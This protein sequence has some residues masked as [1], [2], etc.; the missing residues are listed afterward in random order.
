M[1]KTVLFFLICMLVMSVFCAA[2][3]EMS[4][5]DIITMGRIEQDND[6]NN[7]TE[8]IEWIV[9]EVKDGHA[10]LLS[11]YSLAAK[12][13]HYSKIDMTWAD[14][15]M[16][17]WLN[18][19]FFTT[20]FDDEEQ[21]RI[22]EVKIPA[23]ENP[24]YRTNAGTATDDRIFLLSLADAEEYFKT[25]EERLCEATPYAQKH[26][27]F[28][29]GNGKSEWW[30]RSP[31]KTNEY[32]A[33]VSSLGSVYPAGNSLNNVSCTVRPA[34]WVSLTDRSG[35]FIPY[36]IP[37]TP[38][39]IVLS[40]TIDLSELSGTAARD[41][42]PQILS[43]AEAEEMGLTIPVPADGESLYLGE[44]KS[45]QAE[46]MLAV[47]T[48][49]P[50]AQEM[51]NLN[52]LIYKANF[53]SGGVKADDLTVSVKTDTAYPIAEGEVEAPSFAFHDFCFTD[54]GAEAGFSF[55]INLPQPAG[56]SFT[57]DEA[58]MTFV[59]QNG[60]AAGGAAVPEDDTEAEAETETTVEAGEPA[61]TGLS[62]GD[63]FML[64][65]YEQDEKQSNGPE[66]VEWRVLS[67]EDGI[68][69]VISE[70]GLD[71]RAFHNLNV[72]ITWHASSLRNWLNGEFLAEL[73][74][75]PE[76]KLIMKEDDSLFLLSTEEA[77]TLFASDQDRR[78]LPTAYAIS[79]G[80]YVH[81]DT[82]G[83]IWWWLRT[84]S[85]NND[86]SAAC[87][88]HEGNVSLSGN[89]V[90]FKEVIRPAFYLDLAAY[91]K[92][93]EGGL[94]EGESAA[95]PSEP[96]EAQAPEETVDIPE[97]LEAGDE[98][99][100]G[101]FEQ[102]GDPDNGPEPIEWLTLA[103]DGSKALAVSRYILD[104]KAYHPS[105]GT[106]DW[107][108]SSL[109]K[110]LNDDFLTSSFNEAEQARIRMT[111]LS[112]PGNELFGTKKS[113]DTKDRVFLLSIEDAEN[114]FETDEER[115]DW[116]TD[117]AVTD[118]IFV[119][120]TAGNS[121]WWLRTAGASGSNAAY[122]GVAGWVMDRG[123][124]VENPYVGVRPALWLYLTEEAAEEEDDLSASANRV[125]NQPGDVGVLLRKGPSY[126][127][128][129]LRSILNG[130]S[131][132]LT[133]ESRRAEG[134]DWVR[135]RTEEGH[136]GWIP[137]SSL[138]Q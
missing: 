120:Q 44:A 27:A 89:G 84:Q 67:V 30:L 83:T 52:L 114:Y 48:M 92:F 133:G 73:F 130:K 93:L 21:A 64:G 121:W 38:E 59:R 10:L 11:R 88:R 111:P 80:A 51:R 24:E 63:H 14:S 97:D 81:D 58:E 127:A 41:T 70:Y 78:C 29:R 19:D 100:F 74:T 15:N 123:M 77:R 132:E 104:A 26:G 115:S 86:D 35:T 33:I 101:R 42:A 129:I 13:F 20:A 23:A 138:K 95:E 96:E 71:A 69:L 135:V 9:L 87:V 124:F 76:Q 46:R 31:G 3:A 25:D 18:N 34:F 55:T 43:L 39:P 94:T 4:A 112:D 22:S 79:H 98:F 5:G 16:R 90:I 65:H 8:P 72:D 91:E 134:A 82:G 110:W 66:P 131:V 47:F 50:D 62:A 122:V 102:D 28:V 105:G 1:K 85:N 117:Y 54:W 119:D 60:E 37:E 36:E 53:E 68:A 61:F 113:P 116:A 137:E 2:A 106:V 75:E 32:A 12:M 128:D 99:F 107:N 7:G 136:E 125:V 118:G 57:F 56:F 126:S 49:D 109:R 17:K 45:D 108:G 6:E 40:G 103:V